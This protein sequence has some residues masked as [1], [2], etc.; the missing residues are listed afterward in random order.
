VETGEVSPLFGVAHP[1]WHIRVAGPSARRGAVHT[2]IAAPALDVR[3][4]AVT[5]TP[6]GA[7]VTI[8]REAVVDYVGFGPCDLEG[9]PVRAAAA[10]WWVQQE[11]GSSTVRRSLGVECTELRVSGSALIP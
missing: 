8:T 3:D 5:T 10:A 4:V 7:V 2:V 6:G 1:A 9:H 11:L